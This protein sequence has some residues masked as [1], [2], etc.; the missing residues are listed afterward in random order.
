MWQPILP[1]SSPSCSRP[2]RR[3]CVDRRG[4]VACCT[5][6]ADHR[7]E[8]I[9][10]TSN[11]KRGRELHRNF[12][13]VPRTGNLHRPILVGAV[14]AGSKGRYWEGGGGDQGDSRE[15]RKTKNDHQ[16]S[17]KVR[18]SGFHVEGPEGSGKSR[19]VVT[20]L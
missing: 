5:I 6:G 18:R 8:Q 13:R 4:R 10:P 17:D 7:G 2:P 20:G 19:H 11:R 3:R 16:K 15:E 12:R 14:R 9:P 1:R